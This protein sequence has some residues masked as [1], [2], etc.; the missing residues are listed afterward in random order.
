[1]RHF[2]QPRW[3]ATAFRQ[4]S[5][6]GPKLVKGQEPKTLDRAAAVSSPIPLFSESVMKDFRSQWSMVQTG[7]VDDPRRTVEGADIKC[8]IKK[9]A[10]HNRAIRKSPFRSRNQ[11]TNRASQC[12]RNQW[13]R[14]H[15]PRVH[16][17]NQRNPIKRRESRL[18]LPWL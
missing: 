15:S 2:R 3:L 4:S 16:S 8:Q 10:T 9:I 18:R 1:M 5:P 17:R 11:E 14:S 6:R 13:S 7:F 12:N